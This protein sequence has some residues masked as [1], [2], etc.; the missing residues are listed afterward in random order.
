MMVA[1]VGQGSHLRIQA[2]K[3]N[4][5]LSKKFWIAKSTNRKANPRGHSGH[6]EIQTLWSLRALCGVLFAR[7]R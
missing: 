4:P 5:G 7:L 1:M 3:E 2:T 6:T